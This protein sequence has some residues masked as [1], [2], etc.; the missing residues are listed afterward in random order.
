MYRAADQ[1]RGF[2]YK[3][4]HPTQSPPCSAESQVF[5]GQY[6]STL[7]SVNV[8]LIGRVLGFLNSYCFA[9]QISAQKPSLCQRFPCKFLISIFKIILIELSSAKM[10][11]SLNFYSMLIILPISRLK[12]FS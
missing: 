7:P 8:I 1:L 3:G 6:Q 9:F 11:L 10:V 2:V 4:D 5:T 12:F